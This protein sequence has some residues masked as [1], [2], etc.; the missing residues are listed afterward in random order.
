[1]TKAATISIFTGAPL[2]EESERT[3]LRNLSSKLENCERSIVVICNVQIGGRQIDFIVATDTA[4]TVVEVKSSSLPIKGEINGPWQRLVADGTWRPF[5]NPYQQALECKNRLRDTMSRKQ[6]IGFYYPAAYV[7]FVLGLPQGSSVTGGDFKVSVLSADDVLERLLKQSGCPWPLIQWEAFA[8]LVGAKPSSLSEALQSNASARIQWVDELRRAT[9]SE[10]TP[11]AVQ[12]LSETDQHRDALRA[13][14]LEGAGIQIIGPSGCGKSLAIRWLAVSLTE[15]GH[16]CLMI[17]AKDFAGSWAETLKCE[18]SLL[19]DRNDLGAMSDLAAFGQ[20]FVILV[21]GLNE[22]EATQLARAVRGLKALGRRYQARIVIASQ[23][24]FAGSFDGL[25]VVSISRPSLELKERIAGWQRSEPLSSVARQLLRHVDTG[26]E[27]KIIGQIEIELKAN[28]SRLELI[29]HFIRFKLGTR[30]RS[31]MAG[32]RRLSIQMTDSLSYSIAESGFD[33]FMRDQH[34]SFDDCDTMIATG[35]LV[36]RAGRLS[37]AHELFQSAFYARGYATADDNA[38]QALTSKLNSPQFKSMARDVISAIESSTLCEKVLGGSLDPTLL[39]D[40]ADGELGPIARAVSLGL[41]S[42]TADDLAAEIASSRLVLYRDDNAFNR[43]DWETHPEKSLAQRVRLVTIGLRAG[44][45]T[46]LEQYFRLCALMDDRLYSERVRL[47]DQAKA[48]KFALRSESFSLAYLGLTGKHNFTKV[49]RG[50][51]DAKLVRRS[52][53]QLARPTLTHLTSGQLYFVLRHRF[54]LYGSSDPELLAQEICEVLKVRWRYE[55]YHVRL[56]LLHVAGFVR[57]MRESTKAELIAAIKL[58]D[59]HPSDWAMNSSVIDALKFLG[60]LDNEAELSRQGIRDEVLAALDEASPDAPSAALRVYVAMFDHPF[61]S[62]Y[63]EEIFALSDEAR[64][65][66]YRLALRSPDIRQSLSIRFLTHEV[67]EFD[68]PSDAP[69]FEPLT[70]LPTKDNPMS[71][72]EVAAFVLAVRF[73]ARHH[74]PLPIVNAEDEADRCMELVRSTLYAAA[75][76][77]SD[78]KAL[79]EGWRSAEDLNPQ[80]LAACLSE[81]SESLLDRQAIERPAAYPSLDLAAHFSG[82]I[83]RTCRRFLDEPAP[84]IDYHGRSLPD[85]TLNYVFWVIAQYGDRS[86]LERLRSLVKHPSLGS[87]AV[88][89][90]RSIEAANVKGSYPATIT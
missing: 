34:V 78:S 11:L 77:S 15:N 38:A 72:D 70:Q 54:D 36:K 33:E 75:Q 16:A 58:L 74:L 22:L 86:D 63:A 45:G 20:P 24:P 87:R 31:A 82:E 73:L 18:L 51:E 71:Q 66:L 90:I 42:E 3:F 43:V 8:T 61:D 17:S 85:Q 25:K 46:D 26:F 6:D 80:L 79:R 62:V 59:I 29:E 57:N 68:E 39:V 7:V 83:I 81:V 1:M 2:E 14:A 32:L 40:A 35:V 19:T 27:A 67:A 84:F 28:L 69:L 10:Y 44:D 53:K 76:G 41:L 52:T 5:R 23:S 55:P 50:S 60:A 30:S 88:E 65:R 56:E 12:W 13:A 9:I 37:F 21:D 47:A 49:V 89:T 4:V 64:H 48:A